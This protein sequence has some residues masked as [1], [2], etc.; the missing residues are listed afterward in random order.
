MMFVQRDPNIERRRRLA[1]AMI[2]QGTSAAP[3]QHWLQGAARLAQAISGRDRLDAIDRSELERRQGVQDTF[4]EGMKA[5]E[6][7]PAGVTPFVP[8]RFDETDIIPNEAGL[9]NVTEAKPGGIG[10]LAQALMGNPDTA[11]FGAN[12]ML[13]DAQNREKLQQQRDLIDYRASKGGMP[14]DVQTAEWYRKATP[15]QRK[16][17]DTTKRQQQFLNLGSQYQNPRTGQAFQKDLPPEKDPNY[18]ADVERQKNEEQRIAKLKEIQPKSRA[19]LNKAKT[20]KD[21]IMSEISEA[22]ELAGQWLTTGSGSLLS[23]MPGSDAR[24]LKAKLDSIKGNLAFNELREMRATSPTGGAVGQ[25]SDSEREAMSSLSGTLDQGLEGKDLIRA[26]D[27]VATQLDASMNLVE[28]AYNED[29]APIMDEAKGGK[30]GGLS[31]AERKEL[32]AL[33]KQYGGGQ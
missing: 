27:G 28:Q 2:Q 25:L 22:K 9:Q 17:F 13:S 19:A 32:E 23:L 4:Q 15:E 6:G 29:F 20:K 31:E 1:E 18:I 21:F 8:E 30:S 7:T 11:S 10:A 3:V 14:S 24:L 26:L 12:M 5:Y 33:R 16:A